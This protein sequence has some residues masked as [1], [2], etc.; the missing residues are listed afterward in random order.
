MGCNDLRIE[1]EREEIGVRYLYW[2][3]VFLR[4]IF[5]LYYFFGKKLS[6]VILM[7]FLCEI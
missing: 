2:V 6:F 5:D 1:I 4:G 7:F 3:I